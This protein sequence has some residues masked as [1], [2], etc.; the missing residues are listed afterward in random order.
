MKNYLLGVLCTI[1]FLL[2]LKVG[3]PEEEPKV[4]TKEVEVVK[5]VIKEVP[6]TI[7]KYVPVKDKCYSIP[8]KE[9]KVIVV[10]R[11]VVDY[12]KFK[13]TRVIGYAG[14]GPEGFNTSSS[15]EQILVS[16]KYSPVFGF[17]VSHDIGYWTNVNAVLLTNKTLAIGLG[18][19]F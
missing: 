8:E 3:A 11:R 2:G 6:K 1:A 13:E 5:E 12:E 14:I 9:P 19:G 16:Q 18:I 15:N 17:G 4:I 7:V 10:T